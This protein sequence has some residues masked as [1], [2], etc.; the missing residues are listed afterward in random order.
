[1]ATLTFTPT[2]TASATGQ[3]WNN[4]ANWAGATPPAVPTAADTAVVDTAGSSGPVIFGTIDAAAA[5]TLNPAGAAQ[6]NLFI[7]GA[8]YIPG[9]PAGASSGGGT[10]NVGGAVTD[11]GGFLAVNSVSELTAAGITLSGPTAD[12]GGGGTVAVTGAIANTGVILAN[13][14][15]IGLT[16]PFVVDA[17]SITGAGSIEV[18]TGS[19]LDLT[20]TTSEVVHIVPSDTSAPAGGVSGPSV[21]DLGTPTFG[22]TIGLDP[23]TS[24]SLFLAPGETAGGAT[25]TGTTL[26]ITGTGETIALGGAGYTAG[27]IAPTVPGGRAEV[28]LSPVCF[29]RGTRITT[30]TGAVAV[31]DLRAGDTVR[32]AGGGLAPIVW[33]GRRKFDC[34]RHPDPRAVWPVRIQA[35]AF[36]PGLPERDLLVSPQHA[37]HDEGVLIPARFLVN[38]ATVTQEKLA[39][40]EYFH[41]ELARHDLLLA[42]GLAC[43]SYLDTGDRASFENAGGAMVLH[44][45][46][47][48]WTW[49]A[50]ACAEL[51]VTGP[52]LDAVRAKLAMRAE[53]QARRKRTAA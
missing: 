26:S 47:A 9:N 44:P 34:T 45:D 17:G 51:K 24:L 16:T 18:R 46:F 13:G 19:T 1:M 41:V 7:G 39:S 53:A 11:T 30:E 25:V 15:D 21:L 42:E 40:V 10:L 3:N 33:I 6:S 23:G 20:T 5:L 36:G 50:R 29:A 48:R 8:D 43:E 22:G 2:A 31:E 14:A 49:D 4:P 27:F 35:G 32:L 52:E 12:L 38:G 37:I 28:T